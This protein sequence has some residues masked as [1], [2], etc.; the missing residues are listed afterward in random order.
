MSFD[1]NFAN[2]MAVSF[3]T[4][5]TQLGKI[6]FSYNLPYL[7]LNCL[8]IMDVVQLKQWKYYTLS[9]ELLEKIQNCKLQ[10]AYRG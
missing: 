5:K 4:A 8:A 1:V 3:T 9:A 2:P 10:K 6:P 7:F